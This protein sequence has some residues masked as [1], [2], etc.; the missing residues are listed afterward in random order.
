MQRAVITLGLLSVACAAAGCG[1]MMNLKDE[2][3][4]TWAIDTG[5][6]KT[7]AYPF[8]G[9]G[10]DL[11]FSMISFVCAIP[12][13]VSA[14]YGVA[15]LADV[16]LSVIGDVVTLPIVLDRMATKGQDLPHPSVTDRA[17]DAAPSNPP[18]TPSTFNFRV[19]SFEELEKQSSAR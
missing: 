11:G 19:P 16:P 13:P 8:G 17:P 6:P 5:A 7:P 10:R 14:L 3:A 1:T 9:V 4:P 2:P 15:F 18:L 12:S